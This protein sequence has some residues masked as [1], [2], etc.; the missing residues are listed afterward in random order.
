[1]VLTEE[2][3]QEIGERAREK[4]I[5]QTQNV[6]GEKTTIGQ[7]EI[8]VK[9]VGEKAR[10]AAVG[11]TSSRATKTETRTAAGGGACGEGTRGCEDDAG[12]VRIWGERGRR[13]HGG[14][15]GWGNNGRGGSIHLAISKTAERCDLPSTDV[16]RVGRHSGERRG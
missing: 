8:Y 9:K 11:E 13:R 3:Q 6:Y 4:V 12:G 15:S 10:K 14:R 16:Y 2:T 1:M 5:G 7:T